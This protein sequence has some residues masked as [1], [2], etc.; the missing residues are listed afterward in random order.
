MTWRR[1][2]VSSYYWIAIL[3][4]ACM[5]LTDHQVIPGRG[6]W[7]ILELRSID[8]RFL[9]REKPEKD[10]AK[11]IAVIVIDEKTYRDFNEPLIFYHTRIAAVVDYLVKGGA[12]VIGLDIE[13]PSISL[14]GKV[15]GG[16]DS[17]YT[18]MLLKARR[19][20]VD[21][22]IGFSSS[23]GAPLQT[24]LA[25][26]GQENLASFG[27]TTDADA[28]IRRQQLYF[29]DRQGTYDSFPYLLAKKFTGSPLSPPG[30]TILIDYTWASD[31]PLYSF[32]DVY[33]SSRQ[34]APQK[35]AFRG[36]AVIIGTVLS[37]ED[38]HSTPLDFLHGGDHKKRTPGVLIQAAALDTLLSG[39]FFREPASLPAGLSILF[40]S[41]LTVNLCRRRRPLP[42]ACLA[43]GE[44]ALIVAASV[45]AFNRLFVIRLMP[46]LSSVALCFVATTVLHYYREEWKKKRIR[47]VFASYVPEKVIG[48]LLDTDIEKLTQGEQRELCLFFADIRDFTSFA[49]K[50]KNAPG[51]VVNFLNAYHKEMTEIILAHN[52]TVSQ[53]TG[54]GIFAFFGA[55][56]ASDDPVGDALKSALRMQ[57]RVVELGPVWREYGMSDLRVG[58]G[59]HFGESIVGNIG[60]V[61]KMEYVAIGD[62]TNIAS[63]IEGLTK[64]FRETILM[65]RAAHERV[66]GRVSARPLGPVK[67]KGHS[68]VEVF[69]VDGWK[70]G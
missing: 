27:L 10:A 50:H 36:K 12:R 20:G 56:A 62:N 30:R 58:I 23:V 49:E 55:P 28:L 2:F 66:S 42:G 38:R 41:V 34:G 8:L 68:A 21:V 65:S 29:V 7:N 54:D 44:S 33:V 19:A 51:Q 4:A 24:Y 46:L 1:R 14:E 13:L 67:I 17:V 22:V 35:S 26:A 63:R 69:A 43:V 3:V 57:E 48:Q 9:F 11:D 60:S 47:A 61:K 25:A 53:L 40:V 5:L 32:E 18:R 52:G 70:T 64:E 6:T 39:A 31:I 15:S 59:L 37:A 45:F 16:Y